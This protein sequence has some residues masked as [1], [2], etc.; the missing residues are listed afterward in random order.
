[1]LVLTTSF[2]MVEIIAGRVSN[3]LALI[4]D[5]FHMLSD[6]M[7]LVIGLLAVKYS[8]KGKSKTNT[9]G[10]ARAEVVGALI[11]AVFLVA[12]C[13][14]IFVEAI[15]R[16]AMREPL[17]NA[18]LLLYV[19]GAGL[20]INLIGLCLFHNHGKLIILYLPHHQTQLW[21][22]TQRLTKSIKA[23]TA[24]VKRY[25]EVLCVVLFERI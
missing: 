8:K 21:C 13:F 14:T 25:M 5:A 6:T 23:N 17:E 1:M 10:W 19:G 11:N 7:A 3:S 16:L 2:L 20:L 9:Y 4:A 22:Q 18:D 24:L 15:E 12:L